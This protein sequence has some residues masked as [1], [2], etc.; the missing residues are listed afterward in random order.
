VPGHFLDFDR[1]RRLSDWNRRGV[2][3]GHL[4][5][6][7]QTMTTIKNHRT[8]CVALAF[9]LCVSSPV[10]AGPI[11]ST[12]GVY[13]SL[14]GRDYS[15]TL[16]ERRDGQETGPVIVTVHG[17]GLSAGGRHNAQQ[18]TIAQ[19]FVL[20]YGIR[21]L[22]IDYPTT[23][24]GTYTPPFFPSWADLWIDTPAALHV[25]AAGAA[26][27]AVEA[28]LAFAAALPGADGRVILHGNS[29]GAVLAL[30]AAYDNSSVI[31][32]ASVSGSMWG[33][34]SMLVGSQGD[35]SVL[36]V[37]GVVDDLVPIESAYTIWDLAFAAGDEPQG[38]YIAD[39][40]HGIKPYGL[41]L[42]P[43]DAWVDNI[44]RTPEP[45]SVALL[46]LGLLALVPS[47][48]KRV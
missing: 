34:E 18:T 40:G 25:Q 10:V 1:R 29:A 7:K 5:T 47:L 41:W 20:E 15:Y 9:L 8:V 3:A 45:S 44:L 31:G 37:H 39:Q 33:T 21:V 36:L 19:R 14:D 4:S 46:L 26:L 17:G 22:T 48:R 23:E 27:Q 16:Y 30:T 12:Q 28:S 35:P 6:E 43:M 38:V 24:L 11:T 32:V 13:Y 42:E 2:A